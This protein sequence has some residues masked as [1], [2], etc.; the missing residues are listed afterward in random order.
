M[1]TILVL[2]FA[3]ILLSSQT[4]YYN[5][6]YV[7]PELMK[8]DTISVDSTQQKLKKE[9]DNTNNKLDSIIKILQENE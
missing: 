4:L 5:K 8:N 6:C 7:N 9:I 3:F 1:R 2:L